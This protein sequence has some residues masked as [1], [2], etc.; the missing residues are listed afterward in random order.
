[1]I[2]LKKSPLHTNKAA[3]G[4]LRWGYLRTAASPEA[5]GDV[6]A[7]G[8]RGSKLGLFPGIA[9]DVAFG[10]A[11]QAGVVRAALIPPAAGELGSQSSTVRGGIETGIRKSLPDIKIREAFYYRFC[12]TQY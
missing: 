12:N 2:S 5:L 9:P 4:A 6:S 1:M 10:E 7:P 8:S 11:E 3:L